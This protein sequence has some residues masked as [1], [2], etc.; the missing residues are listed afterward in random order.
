[1]PTAAA[2][3][4]ADELPVTGSPLGGDVVDGAVVV[5]PATE[6]VVV[7]PATEVVVVVVVVVVVDV[8][9]GVGRAVSRCPRPWR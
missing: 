1:M 5:G 2:R 9:V 3:V 6:V 8:V 7:G 4:T